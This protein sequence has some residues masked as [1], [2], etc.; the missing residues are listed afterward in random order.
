MAAK[1]KP[2]GRPVR[3]VAFR[4]T[5]DEYWGIMLRAHKNNVSA[6]AILR[7]HL[8]TS[9]EQF[10]KD[11]ARNARKVDELKITEAQTKAI[12]AAKQ[13]PAPEAIQP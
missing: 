2:A 11:V 12:R 10:A 3:T 1:K 4:V 6:T 13:A 5:E 7:E 8:A 9:L